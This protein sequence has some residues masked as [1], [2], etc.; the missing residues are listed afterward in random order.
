MQRAVRPAPVATGACRQASMNRTCTPWREGLP[1]V[2]VLI[3]G[4][5]DRPTFLLNRVN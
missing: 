2:E 4:R 5:T 1:A 3:G